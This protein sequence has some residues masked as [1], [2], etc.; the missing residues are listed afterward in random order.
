MLRYAMRYPEAV[1]LCRTTASV[2]ANELATI[3]S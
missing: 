1:A 3:F 2:L